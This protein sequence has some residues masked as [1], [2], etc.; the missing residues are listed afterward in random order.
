MLGSMGATKSSRTDPSPKRKL[1]CVQD[2]P[3]HLLHAGSLPGDPAQRG[4]AQPTSYLFAISVL[5]QVE[6]LQ[7]KAKQNTLG[8]PVMQCSFSRAQ[9]MQHCLQHHISFSTYNIIQ[10]RGSRHLEINLLGN[11]EMR[12]QERDKEPEGT[13]IARVF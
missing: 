3:S 10:H 8:I 7:G 6:H 1:T 9:E 2:P 4:T 13:D 11:S 5:P 12:G